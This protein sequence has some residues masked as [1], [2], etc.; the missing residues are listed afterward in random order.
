MKSALEL[1][2]GVLRELDKYGSPDFE[3]HEFNDF[4][5]RAQDIYLNEELK[6][7][8]MV[9]AVSDNLSVLVSNKSI[10]VNETDDSENRS[11]ELPEDYRR[12]TGC[13]A[14]IRVKTEFDGYSQGTKLT[15]PARRMTADSESFSMDNSYFSPIVSR[16][17]IRL[18]RRVKGKSIEILY[19]T[20]MNPNNNILVEAIRLEYIRNPKRIKLSDDYES[21]EGSE[22]PE[23]VDDRILSLCA[24]LIRNR[25]NNAAGGNQ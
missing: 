13:L 11:G 20:P 17:V 15:F 6:A 9:D 22:F 5:N 18:F 4:I 14:V 19:D 3:I 8:D 24:G 7:Y 12:I 21:V 16:H 2:E 1:Y 23:N 25:N 10:P